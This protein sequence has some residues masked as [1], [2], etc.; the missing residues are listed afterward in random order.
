V[1]LFKNSTKLTS[2]ETRGVAY[3][4]SLFPISHKISFFNLAKETLRDKVGRQGID[5]E[6]G[7][8]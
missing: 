4:T 5:L 8:I 1:K 7:K 3:I 6:D 2:L